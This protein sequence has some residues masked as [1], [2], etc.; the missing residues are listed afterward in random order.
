[1]SLATRSL[2]E[3]SREVAREATESTWR[4]MGHQAWLRET[5]LVCSRALTA[6]PVTWTHARPLRS[7]NQSVEGHL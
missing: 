1:M 4:K 5:P 3:R 2:E 7:V 6:S